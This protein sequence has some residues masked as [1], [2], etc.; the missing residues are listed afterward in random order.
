MK[1]KLLKQLIE[2]HLINNN[3]RKVWEAL[4]LGESY[5]Y[6]QLISATTL[7]RS[8]LYDALHRLEQDDFV[9]RVTSAKVVDVEGKAKAGR[10]H[11][12]WK[13]SERGELIKS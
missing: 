3:T 4:E 8:T 7:S 6:K 9:K 13:L 10:P 12:L 5:T 11:K 2:I 1:E